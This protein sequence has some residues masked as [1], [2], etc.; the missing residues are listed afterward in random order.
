MPYGFGKGIMKG[1]D[2][3]SLYLVRLKE[4]PSDR[5]SGILMVIKMTSVTLI[6]TIMSYYT[7]GPSAAFMNMVSIAMSFIAPFLTKVFK[8]LPD[9][10]ETVTVAVQAAMMK[11][12]QRTTV[13]DK[14]SKLQ[15]I[16]VV[17]I[18]IGRKAAQDAGKEW[19][20]AEDEDIRSLVKTN[21]EIT[22]ERQKNILEAMMLVHDPDSEN[23]IAGLLDPKTFDTIVREI[24]TAVIEKPMFSIMPGFQIPSDEATEE[25][26]EMRKPNWLL[27]GSLGLGAAAV[28][29]LMA[30]K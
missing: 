22:T 3:D 7:G 10:L 18:K 4:V 15:K 19:T 16:A 21:D 12:L 30:K 26:E 2:V 20:T 8:K 27:W 25:V 24:P 1:I 28:V 17:F 6:T 14:D 13:S 9:G 23:K 29:K 5:E 11:Y